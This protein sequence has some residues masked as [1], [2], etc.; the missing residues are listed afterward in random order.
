[1]CKYTK[2]RC[3]RSKM[4]K[5]LWRVMKCPVYEGVYTRI[6]QDMY[7]VVLKYK[8]NVTVVTMRKNT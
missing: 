2:S 1:M 6:T 5:S 3:F 4:I 8:N 7:Y